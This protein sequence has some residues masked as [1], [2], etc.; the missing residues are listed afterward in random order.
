MNNNKN[1]RIVESINSIDPSDT[2]KKRMLSNIRRKAEVQVKTAK[3][4][5]MKPE[6]RRMGWVKWV[7]AAACFA[8]IMSV[9]VLIANRN[10]PT[11]PVTPSSQVIDNKTTSDPGA[12]AIADPKPWDEMKASQRYPQFIFNKSNYQITHSAISQDAIGEALGTVSVVGYDE[13]TGGEHKADLKLYRING[14]STEYAVATLLED[15]NVYAYENMSYSPTTLGQLFED[16]N[17]DSKQRFS[18]AA[19]YGDTVGKDPKQFYIFSGYDID[20]FSELFYSCGDAKSVHRSRSVDGNSG[21][22]I[23]VDIYVEEVGFKPLDIWITAD[24]YIGTSLI[25]EEVE[26]NVGERANELFRIITDTATSVEA[27]DE[28]KPEFPDTNSDPIPEG[29]QIA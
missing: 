13:K 11:A 6:T 8:I 9:S 14:V 21:R 18:Y 15:G 23:T 26:F 10:T 20:R 17:L 2:T 24:G 29:P 1:D 7:A 5:E 3:S 27:V 19:T 12:V 28:Y 4:S 25:S 16:L 22:L